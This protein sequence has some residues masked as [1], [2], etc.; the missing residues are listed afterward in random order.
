MRPSNVLF[1]AIASSLAL[2]PTTPVLAQD[3]S[4]SSDLE[5]V[6]VTARRRDES[7]QDAPLTIQAFTAEQLEERGLLQITDVAKFTPGVTFNAGSSRAAGDISIRGM[8]QISAV[9]DNRRDLV[10]VFIDNV[11]YI[12]SPANIGTEDLARVEVIKGPQSALF[13]KATFGGAISL[14]TTTPGDE[15]K[16]KVSARL[17][18]R[19]DQTLSASIEGPLVPGKLAGRLLI[20]DRQ[21]D[22]FYRNALGGR[23]GETDERFISGN[24]SWTPTEDISVRLRHMD[25]SDEY[26]PAATTLIA[27][28]DEHNCGPFPGFQPRPLFGLPPEFTL[29]QSRRQFCGPLNAPNGPVGINTN[30]PAAT[31]NS[32]LLP[33]NEH[34]TTLDHEL[35]ALTADWTFGEGYTFSAIL[36]TQ[37]QVLQQLRDFELAP[38]DRYQF[39]YDNTQ[40]QDTYEFR[41]TSP[42]DQKLSWM[43]GVARLENEFDVIGG[44]I[45]GGLF[46]PGAG[47]PNPASL[48]PIRSAS[49]TDSV[50]ASVGYQFTDNLDVSLEARRQED[51]NTSGAG[52]PSAFTVETTATLPRLLVRYALSDN[53]NL[54]ANY[55]KGNQ[56]TQGYATFFELTPEEQ[57]IAEQNGIRAFAP[58]AEVE[59]FEIGLKYR[60]PDGSYYVNASLYY[61]EWVGRQGLRTIQIDLNGNGVIDPGSAPAGETFNVVPF[62]AGDSETLGVELDGAWQVNDFWSV[63]ANFAY[64]DGE[65]TKALNEVLP[66]RFFGR[67]DSPGAEF[68]LAPRANGAAWAEYEAPLG[69]LQGTLGADSWFARLDTTYIGRRWNSILN[70]AYVPS[71]TRANL[72]IGLRADNWDVTAFVDNLFDDDTLEWSRY[73]SDSATDPFFFQLASS[74]AALANRRQVGVTATYRF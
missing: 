41:L 12:G 36:S 5:E 6:V 16:G 30:T 33:F 70:L 69:E 35:T 45:L 37:D 62:A 68:A 57:A 60:S 27:R 48:N 25:R 38:E 26:G 61:L 34:K 59:N 20:D 43:V 65:I 3:E 14:I 7:L 23:L 13:G 4:N 71:Q 72:R 66:L 29:E 67:N 42:A 64:A 63:G 24:L 17:A 58:E 52:S 39:F 47:G 9:G 21:F 28:A 22:G 50:F 40:A 15:V 10:T 53:T 44:F 74:E 8:T 32:G 54:Y 49:E 19:G 1:F 18:E 2:A 31:V 46:G 55:A 73:Q 11:P 56:P 51:S